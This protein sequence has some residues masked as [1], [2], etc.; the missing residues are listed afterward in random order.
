MQRL[1][2]DAALLHD[3][4]VEL[5]CGCLGSAAGDGSIEGEALTDGGRRWGV[6]RSRLFA[7]V[8]GPGLASTPPMISSIA[9][10]R[11]ARMPSDII[12]RVTGSAGNP[13]APGMGRHLVDWLPERDRYPSRLAQNSLFWPS[14]LLHRCP[15]SNK[16]ML[17]SFKCPL[18]SAQFSQVW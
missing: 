9:S 5:G 11:P 12:P 14:T 15:Y 3:V 7:G 6:T 10:S 17:L 2:S 1:L 16:C 13:P 8:T 18:C 4:Q